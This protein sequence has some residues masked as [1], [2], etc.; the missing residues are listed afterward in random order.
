M[1]GIE[2]MRAAQLL[3][4][5]HPDLYEK[6][7]PFYDKLT[8][9]Q[10][11][12]I[13]YN[14]KSGMDKVLEE[15]KK[16]NPPKPDKSKLGRAKLKLT[17]GYEGYD[18]E[19]AA[20]KT[21]ESRKPK[22][23]PVTGGVLAA[24]SEETM[25]RVKQ[26]KTRLESRKVGPES[27]LTDQDIRDLSLVKTYDEPFYKKVRHSY[28]NNYTKFSNLLGDY[29]EEIQRIADSKFP[30]GSKERKDFVGK[31]DW[32]RGHLI[33]KST[34]P[35]MRDV[36][37]NIS[38]ESA[39]RNK[40]SGATTTFGDMVNFMERGQSDL[41]VIRP[42][43]WQEINELAKSLDAE[44]YDTRNLKSIISDLSLYPVFQPVINKRSE[45][46]NLPIIDRSGNPRSFKDMFN[47]PN[48]VLSGDRD[49][50][51]AE[52]EK[53]RR[54]AITMMAENPEWDLNGMVQTRKVP[55]EFLNGMKSSEYPER[56]SL[57]EIAKGNANV[58]EGMFRTRAGAA[59]AL[60]RG[61]GKLGAALGL[62]AASGAVFAQDEDPMDESTWSEA[63][64]NRVMS[65][66]ETI[67]Q[68]EQQGMQIIGQ[69]P[70]AQA[71]GQAYNKG[72]GF[73]NW[74]KGQQTSAPV[75]YDEFGNATGG[76][77][78]NATKGAGDYIDFARQW[79]LPVE[80]AAM[81]V[82]AAAPRKGVIQS[83][84]SPTFDEDTVSP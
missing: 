36:N 22:D 41:P 1:S 19:E 52:Y 8:I 73:L 35:H 50:A 21:M 61:G 32:D 20:R 49:K 2:K 18:P 38:G 13:A 82:G 75:V 79:I 46:G 43:E 67:G 34:Q 30:K 14:G 24:P 71:V 64:M 83:W 66:L 81:V 12:R 15:V 33:P 16:A 7:Q 27:F 5:K 3:K 74:G 60:K 51:R 47:D 55:D 56:V 28:S 17:T 63:T 4:R 84:F 11:Q 40:M 42:T 31:Y 37:S 59:E 65:A 69:V 68:Y 45:I 44:G 76:G 57:A 10:I 48:G 26:A 23:A 80:D 25:Q 77:S 53:L 78:W 6:V 39:I 58:G 29:S 54:L 72:I 70:G 62:L 9:K